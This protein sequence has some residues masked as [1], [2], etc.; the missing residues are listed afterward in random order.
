MVKLVLD[1]L[2]KPGTEALW[3]QPLQAVLLRIPCHTQWPVALQ[4]F[5]TNWAINEAWGETCTTLHSTSY[6]PMVLFAG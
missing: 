2:N 3:Q 5:W 4:K 1:L 6:F